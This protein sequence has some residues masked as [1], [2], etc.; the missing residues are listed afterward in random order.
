MLNP[1]KLALE[2]GLYKAN[3]KT[4]D[5]KEAL[6]ETGNILEEKKII[7]SDYVDKIIEDSH[8]LNFYY[9]IGEN[10][11]MPHA[12]PK[13]GA[14]DTALA[15]TTSK[16]GINFGNHEFNPVKVIFMI[17][18]LGSDEHIDFIMEIADILQNRE[19]V[20]KLSQ[21]NNDEELENVLRHY[22]K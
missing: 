15:V 13:F 7:T 3:L 22:S 17:S 9:V 20:D 21:C 19:F 16:E 6:R 1:V 11:A 5:W 8:T 10:I 2:K 14:L 18:V 4:T 12:S